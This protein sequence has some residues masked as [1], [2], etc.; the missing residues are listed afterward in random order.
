MKSHRRRNFHTQ[1]IRTARH[2]IDFDGVR[3]AASLVLYQCFCRPRAFPTGRRDVLA[4]LG[5]LA[6]GAG[7]HKK[8]R[9]EEENKR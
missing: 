3:F 1:P 4:R 6:T 8:Q 9:E 2:E 7:D 5:C